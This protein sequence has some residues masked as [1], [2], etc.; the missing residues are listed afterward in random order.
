MKFGEG[1]SN[2][3][4]DSCL[5]NPTDRRAWR[6]T[7]HRVAHSRTRLK[8]LSTRA[9]TPMK[10]R[11]SF[12]SWPRPRP[13]RKPTLSSRRPAR[14]RLSPPGGAAVTGSRHFRL[15]AG[16]GRPQPP[17]AAMRTR[18]SA[19]AARPG[20]ASEVAGKRSHLGLPQNGC[21]HFSLA[22]QVSGFTWAGINEPGYSTQGNLRNS[23]GWIKK[24]ILCRNPG[25]NQGPLDLQSNALPTELFRR[26]FCRPQSKLSLNS[27]RW[28][29]PSFLSNH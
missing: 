2:P 14:I 13:G 21:S 7:L 20:H 12:S 26:P 25:S 16:A 24:E 10:F 28:L 22:L 11:T 18:S 19:S 3:L 6:A 15:F 27:W 1:H 8:Q 5:E 9:R 29:L 17:R 4:Q 23:N